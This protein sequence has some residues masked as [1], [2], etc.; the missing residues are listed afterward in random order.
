MVRAVKWF[1]TAAE[2]GHVQAQFNLGLSYFNGD[3]A[4]ENKTEAVK[5][6]Q[7]AADQGDPRAQLFLGVAYYLGQGAPKNKIESLNWFQKP[8]DQGHAS[9]QFYLAL[10]YELPSDPQA[11]RRK[12]KE[13]AL[14]VYN[15]PVRQ[16]T[17]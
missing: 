13:T 12:L 15:D 7:K 1:K 14:F 9:A 16:V 4:P 8:A 17:G 3:G 6:F 5:W 2:K 10:A 11:R